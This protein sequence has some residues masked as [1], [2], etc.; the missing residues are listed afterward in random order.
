MVS[1]D[2]TYYEP[3]R[4]LKENNSKV[5]PHRE[6]SPLFF[7]ISFILMSIE[8]EFNLW[9]CTVQLPSFILNYHPWGSEDEQ[10]FFFS[11]FISLFRKSKHKVIKNFLLIF[12]N[13]QLFSAILINSTNTWLLTTYKTLLMI[14]DPNTIT[15]LELFVLDHTLLIPMLF[16]PLTQY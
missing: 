13:I 7:I 16:I 1:K 8:H 6:T 11:R 9:L 15:S 5:S 10:I 2:K 3:I 14:I 12:F 4:C